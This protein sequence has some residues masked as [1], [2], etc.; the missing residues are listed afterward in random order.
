MSRSALQQVLPLLIERAQAARDRQA[1]VLRQVQQSA[2]QAHTTLQRLD[3]FQAEC[4]ARSAAGQLGRSD[5]ASLAGYQAFVGR[6]G[7]AIDLQAQEA[8]LRQA[9]AQ[10]QQ[11][12]LLQQ[13]RRVLAFETLARRDAQQRARRQDRLER[14]ATDE[15]A[16]R[17]A[18]QEALP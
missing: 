3:A 4:L 7:E 9:Q 18:A 17:A 16:A 15:F 11:Q 6:L 8:A 10:D 14:L 12:R 1:A 2:A 13:Q 5:G